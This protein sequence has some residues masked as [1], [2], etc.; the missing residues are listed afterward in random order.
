MFLGGLGGED[1][2]GEVDCA[3]SGRVE[4]SV[5]P[6]VPSVDSAF[7]YLRLVF[8]FLFLS[9]VLLFSCPS[10]VCLLCSALVGIFRGFTAP[11]VP[12][13]DLEAA[14][15]V[16]LGAVA[17]VGAD[18]T[19]SPCGA[20]VL[21]GADRDCGTGRVQLDEDL[22]VIPQLVVDL[23]SSLETLS[24]SGDALLLSGDSGV[25]GV[26]DDAASLEGTA[27]SSVVILGKLQS[28]QAMFMAASRVASAF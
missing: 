15:R 27:D 4:D 10:N 2:F 25:G 19:P 14:G 6:L 26:G 28:S 20:C 24:L 18:V 9:A 22:E 1:G 7:D 23:S 17:S 13:Q 12:R 21:R 5:L 8:C 3:G 11:V 16:G